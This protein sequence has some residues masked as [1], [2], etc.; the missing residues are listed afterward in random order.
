MGVGTDCTGIMAHTAHT[1]LVLLHRSYGRS[2]VEL[3]GLY[4]RRK[5]GYESE[6]R[7][8]KRTKKNNK[9]N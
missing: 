2:S 6:T 5:S 9:T 7:G 4:L 8:N 3:T 1:E